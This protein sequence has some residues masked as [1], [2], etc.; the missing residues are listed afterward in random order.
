[1]R[2]SDWSSDVCSSDLVERTATIYDGLIGSETSGTLSKDPV[3]LGEQMEAMG[4]PDA[5]APVAR[6]AHWRGGTVRALRGKA[7]LSA[8]EAVLPGL[9]AAIARAPDPAPAINRLDTM[10]CPLPTAIH[11][12]NYVQARPGLTAILRENP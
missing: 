2:I 6:V 4:F 7:A 3:K 11:F 8:L 1:M 9:M 12:F 5:T 10:I